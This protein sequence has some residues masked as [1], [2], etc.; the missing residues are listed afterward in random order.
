MIWPLL[1]ALLF[2]AL[3]FLIGFCAA[4]IQQDGGAEV[5]RDNLGRVIGAVQIWRR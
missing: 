1:L 5:I 3:G 2:G 4:L